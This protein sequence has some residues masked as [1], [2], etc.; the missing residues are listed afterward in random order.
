MS[1]LVGPTASDRE[2]HRQ[3]TGVCKWVANIDLDEYIV[4]PQGRGT[5]L[6]HLRQQPEVVGSVSLDSS[7]FAMSAVQ[8]G[9]QSI[10]CAAQPLGRPLVLDTPGVLTWVACNDRN[11]ATKRINRG[12]PNIVP[13]VHGA[14]I[15]NASLHR[16]VELREAVFFHFKNP[17]RDFYS[18]KAVRRIATGPLSRNTT[19][20]HLQRLLRGEE[21]ERAP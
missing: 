6:E 8:P 9:N 12:D 1:D 4:I 13:S 21:V 11:G 3:L 10:F 15:R 14:E 19:K 7:P 16:P 18:T 17:C 5:L 20:G 2:G